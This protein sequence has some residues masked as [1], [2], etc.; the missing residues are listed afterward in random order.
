[1]KNDSSIWGTIVAGGLTML[2]NAKL[3]FD[4]KKAGSI[5]GGGPIEIVCWRPVMTDPAYMG[6]LGVS[7]K[8]QYGGATK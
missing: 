1:M 6:D 4:T 7:Y 3:H 5:A 2:S 8:T